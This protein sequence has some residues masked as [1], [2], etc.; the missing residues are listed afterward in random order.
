LR[1]AAADARRTR[2]SNGMAPSR[3]APPP[4]MSGPDTS[5]L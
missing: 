1:R 5:R 3:S 4:S 2:S